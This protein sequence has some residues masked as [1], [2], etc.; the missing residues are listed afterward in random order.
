[1]STL[2][3]SVAT[4]ITLT[5][6]SAGILAYI[7]EYHGQLVGSFFIS[8][9]AY[10]RERT[11]VTAYRTRFALAAISG[12]QSR[13]THVSNHAHVPEADRRC[14]ATA[15]ISEFITEDL[16]EKHGTYKRYDV[17]TSTREVKFDVDGTRQ[18][19]GDA[20]LGKAARQDRLNKEHV[21][22]FIDVDYYLSNFNRY[23]QHPMII[24][25]VIPTALRNK[26]DTTVSRYETP[27]VFS[28]HIGG[29]AVYQSELWDY[30]P[31][32]VR[33]DHTGLFGIPLGFSICHLEKVRQPG[34][35]NRHIVLIA[36]KVVSYLPYWLHMFVVKLFGMEYSYGSVQP[37]KRATN[38]AHT[39]DKEFLVGRFTNP[40]TQVPEV[41]I[42]DTKSYGT[43]VAVLSEELFCVLCRDAEFYGEKWTLASCSRKIRDCRLRKGT[44]DPHMLD[45]A[46]IFSALRNRNIRP[47][48][49]NVN[50][51]MLPEAKVKSPN[52]W[53]TGKLTAE[54]MGY[55]LCTDDDIG[56]GPTKGPL[57]DEICIQGRVTDVKNDVIPPAKYANYAKEFV[58]FVSSREVPM[59]SITTANGAAPSPLNPASVVVQTGLEGGFGKPKPL[60]K[61]TARSMTRNQLQRARDHPC[62]ISRVHNNQMAPSQVRRRIENSQHVPERR[63]RVKAQQKGEIYGSPSHPRNISTVTTTHTEELSRYTYAYSDFLKEEFGPNSTRAQWMCPGATPA[64]SAQAIHYFVMVERG[65]VVETD[66]SRFDGTIS[67]WLRENVEFAAILAW[68]HPDHRLELKALLK[69]DISQRA[70]TSNGIMYHTGGS[71]LSGSPLTTIGNTLINA[72]VAYCALR[73]S[74]LNP[75]QAFI[76]IGPKY[77]DD[78]VDRAGLPLDTVAKDLG[79]KLK[80]IEPVLPGRVSFLGRV[81]YDAMTSPSS[82]FDVARAIR[83]IPVVVRGPRP[84]LDAFRLKLQGYLAADPVTPVLSA[85]CRAI[86]RIKGWTKTVKRNDAPLTTQ[87]VHSLRVKDMGPWP[88]TTEAD[89]GLLMQSV[90]LCLGI[91]TQDVLTLDERLEKVQ[92][93]E[94]LENLRLIENM[95][96]H[97]EPPFHI[98]EFV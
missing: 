46:I 53:D 38:V 98:I 25:T 87:E 93:A 86:L 67:R 74:G 64:V 73:E 19:Y 79:L 32:L 16:G 56:C 35:D 36:P 45:D 85:Y 31:D 8:F 15:S 55:P 65:Q 42:T 14:Q 83:K 7:R 92:T 77:G 22:T 71:R 78:G 29:G 61:Q 44:A 34:A 18:V 21:V 89:D 24:Y 62:D 63:Q 66:Y 91:G 75:S 72:Y 49:I 43:S 88:I 26:T 1:M 11:V 48:T 60:P 58:R 57:S 6:A 80:I 96:G 37:F 69:N 97:K 3:I 9:Y 30:S 2:A 70:T 81:F 33:I 13:G 68:V 41:Q 4:G 59:Q 12:Y 10:E 20:D 50:Y 27:T 51:Q 40:D 23:W 90:A 17:G 28:Q 39:E 54:Y 82:H 84:A 76:G 52:H 94:E 5:A 47:E 95:P